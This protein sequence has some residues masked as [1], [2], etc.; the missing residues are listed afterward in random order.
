MEEQ[1]AA[2]EAAKTGGM[3][4]DERKEKS[5]MDAARRDAIR[6]MLFRNDS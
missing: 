6:N 3:G 5:E 1:E 4:A 2:A